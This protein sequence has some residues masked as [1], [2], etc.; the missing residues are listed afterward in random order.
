MAN[1]VIDIGNSRSKIA[2]FNNRKLLKLDVVDELTIDKVEY[3]LSSE[4]ISKS[5][6]CSVGIDKN[7]VKDILKKKTTYCE[8]TTSIK[9]HVTLLYKSPETLGLDRFA[10]VIGAGAI[11]KGVNCLIIDAG[12]CIT[13]DSV[14]RAGEYKGGSISP[15]IAMRFNALNAFTER[16]P[17]LKVD[18]LFD[19]WYGENT[20]TSILSGV[21]QGAYAEVIGFINYYKNLYPDLQIILCGGD[22]EFFGSRLK[23]SIF[24]EAVKTEPNLVLIGLNEVILSA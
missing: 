19:K 9:T 1:L 2:I 14:N 20:I 10:A 5:I 23:N 3:Y 22:S 17:L 13:Y 11:H 16:L 21:Q 4:S 8:F 18:L 7:D 24:A 15:G 12:T 6:L